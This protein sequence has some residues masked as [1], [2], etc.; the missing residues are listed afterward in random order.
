MG[1]FIFVTGSYNKKLEPKNPIFRDLHFFLK[2]VFCLFFFIGASYKGKLPQH[3]KFFYTLL[4]KKVFGPYLV[5]FSL[6]WTL[7]F[8]FRIVRHENKGKRLIYSTLAL[9]FFCQSKFSCSKP[10]WIQIRVG[11]VHS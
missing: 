4:K 9:E 11:G 7:K 8:H 2:T 3:Y 10:S 1:Q 5:T 6:F